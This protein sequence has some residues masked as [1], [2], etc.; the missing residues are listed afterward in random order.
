M[1]KRMLSFALMAMLFTGLMASPGQATNISF[2]ATCDN[3]FYIYIST[4]PT[5]QGTQ[6]GYG[7]DWGTAFTGST[8]L[9]P[10][11][12]NYL[13]VFGANAAPSPAGFIGDFTLSDSSFMFANGTQYIVTNANPAQWFVSPDGASGYY[14]SPNSLTDFGKNGT[15][16]WLGHEGGGPISGIDTN[17]HWIWNNLYSDSYS[18]YISTA[19]YPVPLPPTVLL[20]G[21]G[22]LGLAGW[23]RLRKINHT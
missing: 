8:A 16:T 20:L 1:K 18:A 13:Q 11:V 5:V 14:Q 23:K 19:I 10:G 4:S 9:T 22:L 6:I 15:E 17:A 21:S 12:V 7:N 2:S 3:A